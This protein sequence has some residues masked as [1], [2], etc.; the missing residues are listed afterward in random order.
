MARVNVH[1]HRAD[2]TIQASANGSWRAALLRLEALL[3][4]WIRA[5]AVAERFPQAGSV[6][7]EELDA[8]KP[9]HTLPCVSIGNDRP[10]RRAVFGGQRLSVVVGRD[11]DPRIE[12]ILDCEIGRVPALTMKHHEPS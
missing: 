11:H 7:R 10:Q 5:I 4:P 3:A 6:L 8:A 2:C 1:V 12:K 9:L